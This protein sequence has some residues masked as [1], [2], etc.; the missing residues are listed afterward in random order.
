MKLMKTVDRIATGQLSFSQALAE[1]VAQLQR[2]NPALWDGKKIKPEIRQRLIQIA[3]EFIAS[4]KV[5]IQAPADIIFVG[6]NANYNWSDASDIDLH[7][8]VDLAK[9]AKDCGAQVTGEYLHDAVSMFNEH[10]SIFINGHEVELYAQGTGEAVYSAGIFSL[11]KNEWLKTPTTV[12]EEPHTSEIHK[13]ATALK[14]RI[15]RIISR[16]KGNPKAAV[17]EFDRMRDHIKNMR[18][19]ALA[20]G[21]E[22]SIENLAFKVIRKDGYMEK[23]IKAA[24]SAY[25]RAMSINE[26]AI[27]SERWSGLA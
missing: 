12:K 5:P 15:D 7:I 19:A 6:S 8:I 4:L 18:R 13:K 2:L 23:L 14:T 17:P 10:H 16:S 26:A 11:K 3:T 9:A 1:A 25:D 21:G 22:H 20:T 27:A 24:R